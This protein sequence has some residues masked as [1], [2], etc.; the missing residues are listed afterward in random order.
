MQDWTADAPAQ[1]VKAVVVTHLPIMRRGRLP[2]W[3]NR[4]IAVVLCVGVEAGPV[5]LE[6][7]AAVILV[8]SV[9]RDDLNLGAAIA[10]VLCVVIVGQDFD[11][12]DG[13][14]VRCNDGRPAPGDTGG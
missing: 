8:G 7:K 5:G 13:I 10:P 2:W 3:C 11:F 4:V 6:E 14:L 1:I 12:F 9:L